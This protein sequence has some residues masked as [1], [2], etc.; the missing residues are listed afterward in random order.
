MLWVI[1]A[2][3]LDSV[4]DLTCL[5]KGGMTHLVCLINFLR[6]FL[7]LLAERACRTLQI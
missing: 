6:T 1:I 3:L 4:N 5:V 2:R 7:L